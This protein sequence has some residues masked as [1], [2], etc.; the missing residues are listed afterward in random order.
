MRNLADHL[1]AI[2][3]LE[4]DSF[5][6]LVKALCLDPQT[7][8]INADLRGADLRGLN[9]TEF[10]LSGADLHGAKVE[11]A[12]FNSKSIQNA[13]GLGKPLSDLDD[14]DQWIPSIASLPDDPPHDALQL[15]QAMRFTTSDRRYM[16][17][18][19]KLLY[20]YSTFR[21]QSAFSRLRAGYGRSRQTNSIWLKEFLAERATLGRWWESNDLAKEAYATLFSGPVPEQETLK[22]KALRDSNFTVREDAVKL[23]G[24]KFGTVE[25]VQSILEYVACTDRN[26]HV[27]AAALN[28]IRL[29]GNRIGEFK[30]FMLSRY[31]QEEGAYARGAA[32]R[33]LSLFRHIDSDIRELIVDAASKVDLDAESERGEAM[34]AIEDLIG[35]DER[36]L[37]LLFNTINGPT[38]G[39]KIKAL[40][41]LSRLIEDNPDARSILNGVYERSD[42]TA[43]YYVMLC[44]LRLFGADE[45]LYAL[46]RG[47]L[48]ENDKRELLHRRQ[49]VEL[50]GHFF[51][52]RDGVLDIV[53][54]FAVAEED[55]EDIRRA[56][57][58]AL[59]DKVENDGRVRQVLYS[60]A[61]VDVSPEVRVKALEMIAADYN[62]TRREA[63]LSKLR[64]AYESKPEDFYF[65]TRARETLGITENKI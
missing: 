29:D 22:H 37:R 9:L 45:E 47:V 46:V 49:C 15:M 24:K 33:A 57:L 1:Q 62:H 58:S 16:S 32:L 48:E 40:A 65:A 14:G 27:R 61:A 41:V 34:L 44:M 8:F 43:R 35:T 36:Y 11:G 4:D 18:L 19:R 60:R 39:A 23:L 38:G 53:L 10:D 42:P 51:L 21:R 59:A 20:R 2:A 56:A 25:E 55:H 50:L 28:S 7:D 13:V 12:K 3:E 52:E 31:Q 54:S 5:I 26:D 64:N 30:S 63:S 17:A 6:A